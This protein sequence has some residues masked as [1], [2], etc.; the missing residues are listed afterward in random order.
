MRL[1]QINIPLFCFLS[2]ATA[3]SLL[4]TTVAQQTP[5][6]FAQRNDVA[7]EIQLRAPQSA[8]I[9]RLEQGCDAACQLRLVQ[10]MSEMGNQMQQQFESLGADGQQ[11]FTDQLRT[12][13]R[14]TMEL[15]MLSG[16]VL[17]PPQMQR[18]NQLWMQTLG[19]DALTS[20]PTSRLLN[21]A[22]AQIEQIQNI[23]N[24]A[25]QLIQASAMNPNLSAAQKDGFKTNINNIVINQCIGV[26][27]NIQI[28]NLAINIGEPFDFDLDS[29]VDIGGDIDVD[30]DTPGPDDVDSVVV[31]QP[32]RQAGNTL[33][34]S[35]RGRAANAA[36]QN[37]GS[38]L[39]GQR[40]SSRD[41]IAGNSQQGNARTGNSRQSNR[42]ARGRTSA[43]NTR[44]QATGNSRNNNRI[45]ATTRN[46]GNTRA[47]ARSTNR[48]NPGQTRQAPNQGSSTRGAVRGGR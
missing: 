22:P 47:S 27:N 6:R 7:N 24:D 29:D 15:E 41:Q 44:G 11:Q 14:E 5:L 46:A 16:Q 30:T 39:R 28:D 33:A 23:Q 9:Q 40:S 21:M 10:A 17:N 32:G 2:F 1:N 3:T 26:L 34:D 43:R 4:S 20:G 25:D 48:N 35:P 13:L 36:E 31:D 38:S 19:L 12:D 45:R 18:F 8:A 42:N 37:Q